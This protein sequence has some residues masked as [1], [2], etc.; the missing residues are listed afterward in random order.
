MGKYEQSVLSTMRAIERSGA[1]VTLTVKVTGAEYDVVEGEDE[2][3]PEDIVHTV[4]AVMLPASLQKFKNM[5]SRFEDGSLAISKAK[6]ILIPGRDTAGVAIADVPPGSLIVSNGTTWVVIV[7]V[8]VKPDDT[9]TIL[10]K[11]GA[12]MI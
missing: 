9:E 12:T 6:Y 1:D 10:Y 5:D 8:P 11:I 7:S 3:A 2:E 4:S